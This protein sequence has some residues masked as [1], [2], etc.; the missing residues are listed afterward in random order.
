MGCGENLVV[1]GGGMGFRV[2]GA[3]RRGDKDWV[4]RGESPSFGMIGL[5]GTR[6]EEGVIIRWG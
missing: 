6:G 5:V 2:G 1:D 3:K 4:L